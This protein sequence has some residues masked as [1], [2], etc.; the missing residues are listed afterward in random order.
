MKGFSQR[1]RERSLKIPLVIYTSYLIYG[2]LMKSFKKSDI[3][4][5]YEGFTGIRT[6]I[7]L[8]AFKLLIKRQGIVPDVIIYGPA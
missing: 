8:L 6:K 2:V 7:K 3:L 1:M 5:V 4:I